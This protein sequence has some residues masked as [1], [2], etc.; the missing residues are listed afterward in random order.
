M[1]I[2]KTAKN[3]WVQDNLMMI[4]VAFFL[5]VII[6]AGFFSYTVSGLKAG[7]VQGKTAQIEKTETTPNNPAV[8]AGQ[9]SENVAAVNNGPQ[10]QIVSN[11]PAVETLVKKVFKHV[12]LPSGDVQVNKVVNADELRKVNPIFYQFAKTGDYVLVYNDRAILYNPEADLVLDIV[13]N[14][15]KQK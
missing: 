11:D 8:Q 15:G 14:P 9:N 7:V 3:Q 2:N 5:I 6:L 1:E 12:F 13:H 4:V 10:V